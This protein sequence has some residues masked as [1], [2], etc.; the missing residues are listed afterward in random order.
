M[1]ES[2]GSL[3]LVEIADLLLVWVLVWAGV[4]WLRETSARVGLAGLGI[5]VALYLIARQVGLTLTTWILQGFVAIAALTA[6]VVFQP[7]LR[8]LFERIASVW[9][10]SRRGIPGLDVVGL[11]TR[12]VANLVE[13]RWGA[14][15]VITGRESVAGQ[16]AGGIPL[17]AELSE[18]LLLSIFDPHSP[19]HDGAVIYSGDRVSRFAGHLPL[20]TNRGQL[21]Q[22]GTRHAA[23]LGLAEQTDALSIIVSEERGTVSLAEGGRLRTLDEPYEMQAA[24]R[25]F[26]QRLAPGKLERPGRL[27]GLLPQWRSGVLALLIAGLLWSLAV[28]GGTWVEVERQV[29]VAVNGIPPDYE[30]D[31]V[32]PPVARVT[33]AGR[34]RDLFLL[35]KDQLKVRVDA[36]LVDLGR[37]SFPLSP[38]AVQHPEGVEVRSIEPERV[39]IRVRKRSAELD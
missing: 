4:S 8:R 10:G 29:P 37:R 1:L 5:L 18:P 20:S 31:G 13:R 25:E 19:G 32:D 30:L 17:D 14:L 28:P 38:A 2:L 23:G 36:N 33:L 26:L 22:R 21:G 6:V 7:E 27:Y 34:R 12:T 35:P 24:V 11:L 16:V 3:R 39:K 9:L 15:I